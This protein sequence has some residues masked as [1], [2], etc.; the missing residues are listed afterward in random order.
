[1][2]GHWQKILVGSYRTIISQII[3]HAD[4]NLGEKFVPQVLAQYIR[5]DGQ[6][7][8]SAY[9]DLVQFTKVTN[10]S[11]TAIFFGCDECRQSPFTAALRREYAD[12]YQMF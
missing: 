2:Q 7:I 6:W 11:H 10:P 8:N 12:A 5:N 3:L 9:Y 1:V 4:I